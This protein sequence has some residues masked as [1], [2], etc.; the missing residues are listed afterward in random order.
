VTARPSFQLVLVRHGLTDWNEEGRLLGRS[1]IGL[2]E[3]GLRQAEAAAAAL[4]GFS[5]DR[6]ISSP[7]VRT[8]ETALPI[9]ESF[10]V[11]LE[12]DDGVD[13][14]WLRESWQG[15]TVSELR[16]DPDLERAIADPLTR[17]DSIE[18]IED[19]QRRGV[20]VVERL[21]REA[22]NRGAVVVSHG[23]PLRV[24]L[25]HYL[26]IPL[27]GF[28]RLLIENGSVSVL[29]FHPRGPQLAVS[30]WRPALTCLT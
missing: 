17:T 10:G 23:D 18:P 14:V 1:D 30:N 29:R 3:R 12:I 4:S 22:P 28:R 5:V 21:R 11:E 13:E 25:A 24:I 9:A 19:V 20:R 27:E 2:N 26:G 6:V 15:K 16:G 7:Q 8:R